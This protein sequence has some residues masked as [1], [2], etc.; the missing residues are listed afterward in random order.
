MTTFSFYQGLATFGICAPLAL[1]I[2]A[3]TLPE[4][5]LMRGDLIVYGF[6]A[7][8]TTIGAALLVRSLY[9]LRTNARMK[10]SASARNYSLTV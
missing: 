9:V 4:G 3:G 6:A 7:V 5:Q 1:V 8:L 10:M 2:Y